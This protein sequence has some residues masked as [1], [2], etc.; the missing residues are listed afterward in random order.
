MQALNH[1]Q[2]CGGFLVFH[3]ND[4][5]SAKRRSL[6]PLVRYLAIQASS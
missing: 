3:V 4:E 1:N 6:F 2:G 5:G